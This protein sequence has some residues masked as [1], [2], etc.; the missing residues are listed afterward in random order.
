MDEATKKRVL[1]ML[2]HYLTEKDWP[3]FIM[4]QRILTDIIEPTLESETQVWKAL[5]YALPAD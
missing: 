5:A 4:S 3:P 1:N 2:E